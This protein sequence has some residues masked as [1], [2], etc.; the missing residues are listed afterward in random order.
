MINNQS[1]MVNIY[2]IC[3]NIAQSNRFTVCSIQIVDEY[4]DLKLY[5]ISMI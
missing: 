1:D 4:D 5:F 2:N 3:T